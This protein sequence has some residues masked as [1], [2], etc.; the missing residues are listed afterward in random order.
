MPTDSERERLAATFDRAAAT[1]ADVR[2]G[3]P[4]SLFD[5]LLAITG[6]AAAA[7]GRPMLL[8]IGAGPGVATR[9][10]AARG[11]HV[12]ALEPGAA[13]A[14]AARARLVGLDVEVVTSRFEDWTPTHAYDLV[15]AATSWHWLDPATRFERAAAALEPQGHLAFWSATHVIPHDGDPFFT[16]LQAVYDSIGEGLPPGTPTPRPNALP[17]ERAEIGA[18][19]LFD[20]VAVRQYD[21]ET[22]HDAAGYIALLDTFSGHIAMQPWQRDRLYGEIRERLARRPDGLLRR[23]WGCVLHIARLR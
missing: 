20:V 8:E 13:L 3:Y 19:G 18:G 14:A 7:G 1:Y 6:L 16:E 9:Q 23:H 4:D 15:Y 2:P 10:L 17:D 12:T 22:V 5:D 21:W 11:F